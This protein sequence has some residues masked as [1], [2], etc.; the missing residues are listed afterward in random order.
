MALSVDHSTVLAT[1][2]KMNG[3]ISGESLVR[4]LQWDAD[5]CHSALNTLLKE[6]IAWIDQPE[7]YEEPTFFFPSIALAGSF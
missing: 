4:E 5:R 1:A 6:G 2:Q 3:I 7:P